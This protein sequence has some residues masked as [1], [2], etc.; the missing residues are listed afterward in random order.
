[1]AKGA[2]RKG[3]PARAFGRGGAGRAA[4]ESLERRTL[5]AAAGLDPTFGTGG[6]VATGIAELPGERYF[7]SRPHALGAS[8]AL[9]VLPDGGFVV[10]GVSAVA[11]PRDFVV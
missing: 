9:A 8:A 6:L 2:G 7:G 5:L 1:M 10:G 3:R 4:C 11:A